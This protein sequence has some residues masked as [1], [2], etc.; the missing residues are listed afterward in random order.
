MRDPVVCQQE[1][2]G[3][4][5]WC[6]DIRWYCLDIRGCTQRW[7]TSRSGL[8]ASDDEPRETAPDIRP[9]AAG[10]LDEAV[11]VNGDVDQAASG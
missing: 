5:D 2:A 11:A 4:R 9:R 7:M 10:H 1:G 6:D 3:R 8:S